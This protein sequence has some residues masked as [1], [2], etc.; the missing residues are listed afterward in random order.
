MKIKQVCEQT[1]LTEKAVRL[2]VQQGLI[3]PITTTGTQKNSYEFTEDHIRELKVIAAFRQAGFGLSDIKLLQEHPEQLPAFLE[4]KQVLMTSNLENQGNILEALSRLNSWEKGSMDSVAKA[5]E[6]V[7]KNKE[8]EPKPLA[9]HRLRNILILSVILGLLALA[10][11]YEVPAYIRDVL[12][13]AL[14]I[15]FAGLI[16]GGILTGLGVRYAT[17]TRRAQKLP[18]KGIGKIVDV[19]LERGIDSS[20][21][22]AG[23]AING[24]REQGIGGNWVFGMMF[25][26][27]IRPDC[28]YPII[29]Y[30]HNGKLRGGTFLYGGLKHTWDEQTEVS[31]AWDEKEPETLLPLE[32]PW[33]RKKA[34]AYILIGL[35]AVAASLVYIIPFFANVPYIS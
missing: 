7:V 17:C 31:I 16:F 6:P 34:A 12:P 9:S 35:A 25:F 32:A 27:E 22:R 4:E 13:Y 14:G 2:Y 3:H 19:T 24:A 15:S 1:G 33:L 28:W 8:P 29:Q 30:E 21:I 20:F 23:M 26:N 18:N 11:Y 10:Y 5:L